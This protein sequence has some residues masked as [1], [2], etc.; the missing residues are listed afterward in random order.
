[1]VDMWF[2]DFLNEKKEIRGRMMNDIF[3]NSFFRRK[4]TTKINNKPKDRLEC[5]KA[6]K[7]H[8]TFK[9]YQEFEFFGEDYT[10]TYI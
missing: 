2:E 6:G 3:L 4:K 10:Y 5:A 8:Q 9:F 1:M 7:N